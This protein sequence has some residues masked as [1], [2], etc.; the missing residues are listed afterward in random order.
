MKLIQIIISKRRYWLVGLILVLVF[1]SG[2]DYDANS[3]L[4]L[5]PETQRQIEA[6]K[7]ELKLKNTTILAAQSASAEKSVG[8]LGRGNFYRLFYNVEIRDPKST[9]RSKPINLLFYLISETGQKQFIDQIEIHNDQIIRNR[10]VE[11]QANNSSNKIGF[12]KDNLEF[13]PTINITNIE[14]SSLAISN[15]PELNALNKTIVGISGEEVTLE[16]ANT[17]ANQTIFRSKNQSVGEFF[18]STNKTITGADFKL[19]FIGSGGMGSYFV[20]LR[21]ASNEGSNF[22]KLISKYYFNKETANDYFKVGPSTYHF[23]IAANLVPGQRYYIGVSNTEV[24]FSFFHTIA[25]ITGNQ[26]DSKT[27]FGVEMKS[28]KYRKRIG[29]LFLR[30][31][32]PKSFGRLLGERF[33]DI[34]SGR[35]KYSYKQSNKPQD[36]LDIWSSE[37][38]SSDGVYYDNNYGGILGRS[39]NNVSYIFK[40]DGGKPIQQAGIELNDISQGLV[41]SLVYYSTDGKNWQE[42]PAVEVNFV[43][44]GKFK[45]TLSLEGKSRE[46]YIKVTY[47][48]SDVKYKSFHLFGIQS[49][50]VVMETDK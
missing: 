48:P 27:Q 38:N 42:I 45:Q 23:P 10:S 33:E 13:S 1:L 36:L 41:N 28:E 21:E 12:E 2:K 37:N 30:I 16:R 5:R 9:N 6:L 32:S 4:G 15:F 24:E 3:G 34:G 11:F 14:I 39:E 40:F 25:V 26:A 29:D 46:L 18:V 7:S 22:G 17:A 44:T 50:Q 19:R 31:Y 8:E 43:T 20:E 35:M 49:L 47:D